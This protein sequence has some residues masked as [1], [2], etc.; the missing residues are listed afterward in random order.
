MHRF[1]RRLIAGLAVTSLTALAAWIPTPASGTDQPGEAAQAA[2]APPNI[3]LVLTDDLAWN[4]VQY[5]PQVQRL[6]QDGVTFTNYTVTDSL[7][8]PSRSSIF[9]GE[10]PHDTGV[11]TNGG[12]DGGFA[13]F[14]GRGNENRTFAT[15]LQGQGYATAMMG[16]YLNGYLPG[17][18]QGGSLPYVPPGWSD[19]RVA[20]NGYP[21]YDYDLNENHTVVHYGS[22]PA[23]YLTDVVS[24]KGRAFIRDSVAAGKPFLLEIATFAPHGPF[25]PAD[26]DLNDFPGLTAPRTPAFNKLPANAPSWLAGNGPLTTAEKTNIDTNFRKRAQAVQA[27][28]RLIRDLRTQLTASGVADNTYLVFTSDNG[29]HMGE[30]RLTQGKMTAFDT[31]IRVPLVVIGPGVAP[32]STRPEIV[33]NIDLAPT[34]Q[35]IGLAAVDPNI[36]GRSLLPLLNGEPATGWRTA[37]LIEHHGP[38]TAADDPDAQLARAGNPT[39]YSA[40]RTATY[41]YVEYSNGEREYYDRVADPY[42]LNNIAG[43]LTAA[44]LAALHTA[45]DAL[46]NCHNQNACWTAG[47]VTA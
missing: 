1:R 18:T 40:L 46:V 23:D 36:N 21:E 41:T 9:T 37:S 7:C 14:K 38:N 4:L 22:S 26:E 13:V 29:F 34:F 8:C 28:D 20:G 42:Q 10:F 3:V 47:H 11:F 35:R 15:A 45:L 33:Q 32:G 27:V 44:R 5:M 43:T 39:T 30:Y 31:D 19:W 24:G 12:T 2:A 25:T 16:K 6:Q 17:D